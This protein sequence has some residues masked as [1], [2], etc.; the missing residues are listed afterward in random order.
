MNDNQQGQFDMKK[1]HLISILGITSIFFGCSSPQ[2]PVPSTPQ[3]K[4]Y[5]NIITKNI[6]IKGDLNEKI[7]V[8]NLDDKR[9]SDGLL[10]VDATMKNINVDSWSWLFGESPY[11][12]SYRWYWF[13]P[14][15]D[16]ITPPPCVFGHKRVSPGETFTLTATAPNK[17]CIDY[18]LVLLPGKQRIPELKNKKRIGDSIEGTTMDYTPPPPIRAIQDAPGGDQT[19]GMYGNNKKTSPQPESIKAMMDDVT[20]TQTITESDKPL[21]KVP[22][23]KQESLYDDGVIN[24]T[25]PTPKQPVIPK[26]QDEPDS[27]VKSGLENKTNSSNTEQDSP[28]S[29]DP[30]PKAKTKE[31]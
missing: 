26:Q 29:S 19:N 11:D 1:R 7:R 22:T 2:T 17:K 23:L 25:A 24:T 15:L 6:S 20:Q 12:V 5:T 28:K 16:D 10:T 3:P 31:L 9:D 21:P 4:G 14:A 13:T 8:T 18:L 30:L 27:K